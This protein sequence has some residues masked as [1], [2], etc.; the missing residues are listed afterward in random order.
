MSNIQSLRGMKDILN[1][2][3]TLF[4]YFIENASRIAKNYGYSYIETPI[5]EETALFKR[6]VGESSDIVNKEMYQFTDKGDNDVCLRPEGTAGVVRSFVQNKFDR[7]GGVYKFYYYGSMFRYERPQKGRLRQFHQFGCESFGETSIYEDANIICMIKDIFDFFG[8]KFKL[9]LNS[10]GCDE[11]M[12][13]YKTNLVEHLN[14]LRDDLCEDCNR[15]IQ[16]NPIRVLD[17]KNETCKTLLVDAPKITHNLCSRCHTNFEAL[18]AIL[19]A[20]NIAYDIDT[21]LVRGLDYYTQTAF[22]FV[23]DEIGA[24][25]A[26]AGG[27]RYDKLVEFLGG[28]ATPAVGFAIGIERVWELI[29][30]KESKKEYYYFGALNEEA[31]PTLFSLAL[32]KRKEEKCYVEYAPRGFNKHFKIAEKLNATVMILM[33]ENELQTQT[34]TLKNLQTKEEKTILIKEF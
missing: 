7:A 28:R 21:N 11:C 5:L 1:E 25:S 33:G 32:K 14:H 34:I 17:C 2:E 26:I 9:L 29:K 3:S 30:I 16:T 27:G 18:K 12:P 24:Q 4:T 20:N 19:T 8:I 31:L 13:S 22:E 6:S 15:R 10:L 23:S